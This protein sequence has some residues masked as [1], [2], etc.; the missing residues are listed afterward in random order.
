MPGS[1]LVM[2]VKDPE[3]SKVKTRLAASFDEDKVRKLYKC[4]VSDLLPVLANGDWEFKVAF[5]PPGSQDTVREWLGPHV[6]LIE[7]TG[8]DLGER[9]ENIFTS[10]FREQ[11]YSRIILTGSDCPDL[12]SDIPSEAFAFLDGKGAVVG[13]A[14]DGGY[15]LIGFEKD[16]FVPEIFHNITWS[17]PTVYE[18]TVNILLPKRCVVHTLPSMSDIDTPEDLKAFFYRHRDSRFRDSATMNYLRNNREGFGL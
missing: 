12:T 4:F 15:Y 7:Q 10:L 5:H 9:M 11:G 3:R 8:N 13:P 6:P 18:A 17:T 14:L 1:A 16:S 2:M